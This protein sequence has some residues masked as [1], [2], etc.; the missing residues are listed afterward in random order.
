M[1]NLNWNAKH[2]KK[3]IQMTPESGRKNYFRPTSAKI[4]STSYSISIKRI[5]MIFV[6]NLMQ[7]FDTAIC[8]ESD[9]VSVMNTLD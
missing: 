7:K 4:E 9:N 1:K 2:C 8:N 3:S 5:E 6:E